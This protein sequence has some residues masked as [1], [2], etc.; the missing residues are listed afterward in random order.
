MVP[1]IFIFSQLAP[2]SWQ[3]FAR[4]F[5]VSLKTKPPKN[6]KNSF[7][8]G[9]GAAAVVTT[10]RGA[11]VSFVVLAAASMDRVWKGNAAG[12]FG[13]LPQMTTCSNSECC[14]LPKRDRF[15]QTKIVWQMARSNVSV[16]VDVADGEA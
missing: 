6:I 10:R 3:P 2:C 14:W 9:F 12:A 11:T 13:R 16:L 15:P 5:L 8:A 4:P 1:S 7:K